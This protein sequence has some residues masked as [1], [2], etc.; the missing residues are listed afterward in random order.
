MHEVCADLIVLLAHEMKLSNQNTRI[1]GK[2]EE[3]GIMEY[4]EQLV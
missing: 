4:L 3:Y 2:M 1:A